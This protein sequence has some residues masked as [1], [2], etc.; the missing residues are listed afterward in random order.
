MK[1]I[2]SRAKDMDAVE[3]GEAVA[4]PWKQL[5]RCQALLSNLKSAKA[6]RVFSDAMTSTVDPVRNS[7][8]DLAF[9]GYRLTTADHAK[10]VLRPLMH[11]FI[12]D[13]TLLA[14]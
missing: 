3:V 13:Y 12:F 11:Q 1:S 9:G 2:R 7:R 10:N 4:H 14:D 5:Q 6:G 8:N